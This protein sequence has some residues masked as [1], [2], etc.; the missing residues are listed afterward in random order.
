M[1]GPLTSYLFGDQLCR[2]D[3]QKEAWKTSNHFYN[4]YTL[5]IKQY[6]L[7]IRKRYCCV[8]FSNVISNMSSLILCGY[9]SKRIS[10]TYQNVGFLF[11]CEQI[12]RSPGKFR[13]ILGLKEP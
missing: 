2:F 6:D 4:F 7:S 9:N 5:M 1:L 13:V 8:L 3:M 11:N 12:P 10:I